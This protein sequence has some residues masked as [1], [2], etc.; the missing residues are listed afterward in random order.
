M[1]VLARERFHYEKL[2]EMREVSLC[3][4]MWW[5]HSLPM[6]R[7]HSVL[8]HLEASKGLLFRREM[9]ARVIFYDYSVRQPT[10]CGIR[11][12]ISRSCWK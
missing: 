9:C 7:V 2:G 5:D 3:I 10:P 6:F 12:R 11:G 8:F 4:I 1:V